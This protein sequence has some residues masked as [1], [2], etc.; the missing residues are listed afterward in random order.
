MYCIMMV[1]YLFKNRWPY[2]VVYDAPNPKT[3]V[4]PRGL[5]FTQTTGP[6]KIRDEGEI[7]GKD[8][9][10]ADS[11]EMKKYLATH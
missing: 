7:E 6:S 1:G 9:V 4:Q 5:P 11:E 8:T 3:L 10:L 2:P